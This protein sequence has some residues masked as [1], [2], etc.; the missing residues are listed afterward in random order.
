M[1]TL[2]AR[3]SVRHSGGA[4]RNV[5]K[6][7]H[8]SVPFSPA[9]MEEAVSSLFCLHL[10]LRPTCSTKGILDIDLFLWAPHKCFAPPWTLK[11]FLSLSGI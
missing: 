6:T 7:L 5:R 11:G 8:L 9:Q 2:S 3:A 4:T 10:G 1:F